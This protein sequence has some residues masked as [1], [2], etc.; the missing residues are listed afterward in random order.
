MNWQSVN[1]ALLYYRRTLQLE[2]FTMTNKQKVSVWS[3]AILFPIYIYFF[4]KYE[5]NKPKWR[6]KKKDLASFMSLSEGPCAA[7]CIVVYTTIQN[8]TL[9]IPTAWQWRR[10]SR[11]QHHPQ[12]ISES[13]FILDRRASD[14]KWHFCS[15]VTNR[16]FPRNWMGKLQIIQRKIK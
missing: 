5:L 7:N 6:K 13:T 15:L 12:E 9:G 3:M 8:K 2:Y 11:W 14:H 16:L 4:S 1:N 10:A